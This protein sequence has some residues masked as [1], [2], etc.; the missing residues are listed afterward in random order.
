MKTHSSILAWR[1][2][3]TEDP[4]GLQSAGSQRV[5]NG[6]S[7]WAHAVNLENCL[8]Y[9][10]SEPSSSTGTRVSWR[11]ILFLHWQLH[12]EFPFVF[13]SLPS[14]SQAG[15]TALE[16]FGQVEEMSQGDTP[17][18]S[19]SKEVWWQGT[20]EVSARGRAWLAEEMTRALA[21]GKHVELQQ[22]TQRYERLRAST[23]VVA[24]LML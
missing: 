24:L 9:W 8:F 23:L 6:W 5:E 3:W 14:L 18:Q 19:K 4:S 7:D 22:W 13:Q 12:C 11:L 16:S 10:V 20:R 15:L 1:I 21:F 2:P 17:G